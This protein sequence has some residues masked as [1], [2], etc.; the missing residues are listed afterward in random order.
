MTFGSTLL[1]SP[2]L[3]CSRPFAAAFCSSFRAPPFT[4]SGLDVTFTLCPEPMC[5]QVAP[6]HPTSSHA[7]HIILCMK[8]PHSWSMLLP[9]LL[10]FCSY[11]IIDKQFQPYTCF[12]PND[13]RCSVGRGT[14]SQ[15]TLWSG[16]RRLNTK[17]LLHSEP[18]HVITNSMNTLEDSSGKKRCGHGMGK[19]CCPRKTSIG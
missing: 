6:H 9:Y 8:I 18:R 4:K 7:S 13:L 2:D 16:T 5:T 15:A 1:H 11:V 19:G 17:M 10:L 12:R 14:H 3:G